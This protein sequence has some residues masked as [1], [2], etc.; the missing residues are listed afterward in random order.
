[1]WLSEVPAYFL[2]LNVAAGVNTH[3]M[4]QRLNPCSL[5]IQ[6]F[7]RAYRFSWRAAVQSTSLCTGSCA[8]Q[9]WSLFW[10]DP[11]LHHQ[12][13]YIAEWTREDLISRRLPRLRARSFPLTRCSAVFTWRVAGQA[14]KPSAPHERLLALRQRMN[15]TNNASRPTGIRDNRLR[16]L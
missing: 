13:I 8:C 7:R 16:C 1:M 9:R 11:S 5:Y 15:A 10:H 4:E 14:R 6:R 3:N 12:P 2:G